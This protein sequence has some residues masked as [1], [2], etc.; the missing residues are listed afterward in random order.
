MFDEAEKVQ[1]SGTTRTVLYLYEVPARVGGEWEMKMPAQYAGALAKLRL[2][3]QPGHL[4]GTLFFE[5]REIPIQN[6][7]LRAGSLS[8]YALIPGRGIARFA[9]QVNGAEMSGSVDGPRAG[10]WSARRSVAR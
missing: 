5:G 10:V 4:G 8:F 3:Q 2:N 6:A 7:M 1:I 9:G